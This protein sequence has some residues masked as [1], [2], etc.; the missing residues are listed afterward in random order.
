M[1]NDNIDTKNFFEKAK[2]LILAKKKISNRFYF[3][4]FNSNFFNNCLRFL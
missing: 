1:E 2:D 3:Y 4:Y